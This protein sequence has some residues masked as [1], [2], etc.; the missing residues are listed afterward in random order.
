MANFFYGGKHRTKASSVFRDIQRGGYQRI[1]SIVVVSEG[2][3]LLTEDG[4]NLI[5]ENGKKIV[6]E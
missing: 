4:N 2:S 5:T 6:V 3:G 1:K